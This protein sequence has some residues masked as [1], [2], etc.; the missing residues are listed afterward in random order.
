MAQLISDNEE[1]TLNEALA[2]LEEWHYEAYMSIIP[3]S[4]YGDANPYYDALETRD[5]L[6]TARNALHDALGYLT[7]ANETI[8]ENE[9][10][11]TGRVYYGGILQPDLVATLEASVV[12]SGDDESE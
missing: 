5:Q 6:L 2:I 1:K 10:G 3:P 4:P 8:V 12:L 11:V 9:D 7:E